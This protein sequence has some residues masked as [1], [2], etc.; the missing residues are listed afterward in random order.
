MKTKVDKNQISGKFIGFFAVFDVILRVTFLRV[1]LQKRK[2]RRNL[3]AVAA[4]A[5][6]HLS[7]FQHSRS[8]ALDCLLRVR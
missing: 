1:S 5:D 4:A 7:H 3:Q 2:L 6:S 8:V